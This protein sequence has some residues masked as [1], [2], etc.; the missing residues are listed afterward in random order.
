[1]YLVIFSIM[2]FL[3]AVFNYGIAKTILYPP[4]IFSSF[5][6]ALLFILALLGNMFYSVSHSALFIYLMGALAFSGGAIIPLMMKII[7]KP[8]SCNLK[9]IKNKYSDV[10]IN[11]GLIASVFVF[12]YYCYELYRIA[13]SSGFSNL[14]IGLRY[15]IV[16]G[17]ASIGWLA[18]FVAFV[19]FLAVFSYI[20]SENVKPKRIRSYILIV[21]SLLYNLLSM[22]RTGAVVLIFMLLGVKL[23]LERKI[24]FKSI[25]ILVIIVFIV[26][27]VPAVLLGK[28]GIIGNTLLENVKGVLKSLMVYLL[29]GVVA[30]D[31]VVKNPGLFTD[32]RIATFRFF[33]AFL[34][35]IGIG[36]YDLPKFVSTVTYTPSPTNVYTIYYPYFLDY[37]YVGIFIF[38]FIIGFFSSIVFVNAYFKRGKISTFLYGMVIAALLVSNFD[39][40]F[41]T[42][43]SYWLQAGIFLFFVYKLPKLVESPA[44]DTK[45]LIRGRD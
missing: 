42:T 29:G 14:W 13:S 17:G 37:G 45:K 5:W 18:Y 38:P 24:S 36:H 32:S 3:L 33:L 8:R 31:N 4:V 1:M 19:R 12:P 34:N 25:L 15:E 2:L 20:E 30:F 41:F 10:I 22:A 7:K 11:I 6:A 27:A 28:G 43:L 35:R 40:A 44:K 39:E 9:T 23:I 26:F 16:Y 21:L